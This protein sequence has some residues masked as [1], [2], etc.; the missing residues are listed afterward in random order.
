MNR[1][2]VIR[3][4]REAGGIDLTTTNAGGVTAWLGTG[5]PEFLERFAALVAAAERDRATKICEYA[6]Q[7]YKDN[8]NLSPD[9][10]KVGFLS[11]EFCAAHIKS[12]ESW[13]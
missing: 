2:D 5:T 12:G 7:M 1:E 11:A 13:S 9:Q 8:Q 10:S 4:A 3:M 6:M